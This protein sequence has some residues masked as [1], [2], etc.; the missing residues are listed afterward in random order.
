MIYIADSAVFIMG[1]DLDPST[2]VTVS[3]VVKEL[4]SHE[5]SMRF[6]LAHENGARVESVDTVLK[7]RV[8]EAAGST[9]DSEELSATDIDVLAKA[10]EYGK[11]AVLLT[12]DYAV[13]NTASVLGIRVMPVVQKKIRDVLEW[14]K[15]C[16]GCRRR[17]PNGDICP[18]CGSQL[19]KKRKR[20]I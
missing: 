8:I 12:D 19:N 11:D 16:F 13:Q 3:S 20:K 14:E 4:R 2:I 18:V 7:Q 1:K 15:E 17:F 6:E 10:L 9:R 5:A